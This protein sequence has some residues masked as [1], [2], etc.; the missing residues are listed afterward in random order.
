MDSLKEIQGF[1]SY[2]RDIVTI[3]LK[4]AR[5]SYG[6]LQINS[7]VKT[8]SFAQKLNDLKVLEGINIFTRIRLVLSV[9][10]RLL[11]TLIN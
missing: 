10:L 8:M 3:L 4:G 5:K 11:A 6:L 9:D 1:G 2:A 7:L